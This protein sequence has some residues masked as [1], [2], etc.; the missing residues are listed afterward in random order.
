M[1]NDRDKRAQDEAASV[2]ERVRRESELLGRSSVA[3]VKR[4]MS[5]EEND[6]DGTPP[7]RLEIWAR[8]IGRSLSVVLCIVLVLWLMYQLR[9]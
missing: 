5:G 8:R 4:H 2:F 9:T 7:D 6:V 1:T 3:R